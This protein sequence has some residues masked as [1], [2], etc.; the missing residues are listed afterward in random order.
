MTYLVQSAGGVVSEFLPIPSRLEN[1]AHS[2]F[3]YLTKFV[4]PTDLACFYPRVDLAADRL[5][6]SV[7]TLAV[8][9]LIAW[10]L[11]TSRP[12]VL[13]GWLWFLGACVP[14]IGL[15]QVGAQA[16]ADRYT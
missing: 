7:A 11:R 8:L 5:A 2:Y 13:V 12:Y 6:L 10:R 4:F 14:M 1:A 3:V 16:Y 15:V 9:T